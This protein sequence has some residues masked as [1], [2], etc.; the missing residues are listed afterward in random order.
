MKPDETEG[1][2]RRHR[3]IDVRWDF[4]TKSRYLPGFNPDFRLRATHNWSILARVQTLRRQRSGPCIKGPRGTCFDL[5]SNGLL[6]SADDL[7]Q[8]HAALCQLFIVREMRR[9]NLN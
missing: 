6:D 8:E 3:K 9:E 4:C 1:E 2:R 5:L 7:L